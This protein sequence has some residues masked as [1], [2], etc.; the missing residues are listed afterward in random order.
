M[1]H[2]VSFGF[3]ENSACKD[4]AFRDEGTTKQN[5]THLQLRCQ[6]RSLRF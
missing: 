5:L 6:A 3:F 4:L 2:R 1:Q